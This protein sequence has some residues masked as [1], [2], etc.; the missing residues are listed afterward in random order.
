MSTMTFDTAST[1]GVPR[2]RRRPVSPLARLLAGLG[3]AATAVARELRIRQAGWQLEEMPD[4]MLSD[5]GLARGD[6]D[7]ALR[8]GRPWREGE[9]PEQGR[10]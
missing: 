6:I 10:L 5:I 2:I 3:R 9:G 8:H 4:H 7:Y 1:C